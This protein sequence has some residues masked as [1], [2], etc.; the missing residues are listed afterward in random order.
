MDDGLNRPVS[1]KLTN[2]RPAWR[3]LKPYR[4]QVLWASM[5]L[6]MTAGVTL[7]IGQGIRIVIDQ[8]LSDGSSMILSQS[9]WFFAILVVVLTLGTFVRFYFVSWVGERVSADIRYAVFSH[10]INLHPG[11]F[12]E[13]L[14][15]EI[16]SRITTDTTLLQTVIGSS[17]SIALRNILMFCGGCLLYTSDAADE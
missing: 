2:L 3:F 10:L 5:A 9:I 17:V 12:E 6:V 7:S 4:R 16:Q 1:K 8:G 11:F 13:N 15:T 14:P